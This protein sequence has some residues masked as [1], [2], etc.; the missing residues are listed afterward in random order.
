MHI[1]YQSQTFG[2]GGMPSPVSVPVGSNKTSSFR[3]YNNKNAIKKLYLRI[4]QFVPEDDMKLFLM[5]ALISI[6]AV[7]NQQIYADSPLTS[8]PFHTAYDDLK[9][10]QKAA[11]TSGTLTMELMNFLTKSTQ[12]VDVKIAVISQLG[13]DTD[14]T[15]NAGIFMKYLKDTD[16]YNS[17]SDFL[18][19]AS[20]EL[21][22][23]MAYLMALDNYFEVDQARLYAKTALAKNETSYTI[24]IIGALI[25]AQSALDSDWSEVYRLTHAVRSNESLHRD[26]RQDAIDIIF[27]YTDLYRN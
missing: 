24:A 25:E 7:F 18:E 26:M 14:G 20:G 2:F 15:D 22:I 21:I 27:G 19:N 1:F 16:R 5:A 17:R 10:V 12:P 3:G 6:P 4:Q 23:C 8:T 11:K 9:I 13:W